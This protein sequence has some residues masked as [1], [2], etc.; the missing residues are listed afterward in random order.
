MTHEAIRQ[1][2]ADLAALIADR[3]YLANGVAW[4]DDVIVTLKAD[5]ADLE[6][7][8]DSLRNPPATTPPPAPSSGASIT[9]DVPAGWRETIREDFTVDCAEGQFAG[10]YPQRGIKFYPRGYFDTRWKQNRANGQAIRGGEYSADFI[11]V[12]GSDLSAAAVR[13]RER[14]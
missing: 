9:T 7:E 14:G 13:E 5:V 1:H 8:V 11:S 3:D 2:S 10:I 6:A 4:R 12:A